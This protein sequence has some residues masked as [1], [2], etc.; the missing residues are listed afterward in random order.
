MNPDSKERSKA[1]DVAV[2]Q[3]ERQ[4]GKGAIMKLGDRIGLDVPVIP[5]SS[6][7][8]DFALRFLH[9]RPEE[10]RN[11]RFDPA[12]HPKRDPGN[13]V[14]L[15]QQYAVTAQ[16]YTAIAPGTDDTL[17]RGAEGELRYRWRAGTP[18]ISQKSIAD[19][20][21][22]VPVGAGAMEAGARVEL[23]MFRWP[24]GRT[25]EEVLGG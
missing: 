5:T 23:E 24:E 14:H 22:V 12:R 8:V 4:F 25:R 6:L 17:V 19:G 15:F 18:V 10:F 20:L 1:V 13:P 16:G 7:S 21:A 11:A 3:I 9:L 2:S